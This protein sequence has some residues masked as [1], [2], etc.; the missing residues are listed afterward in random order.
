MSIKL[1]DNED[2]F[3]CH[4]FAAD[5]DLACKDYVRERLG[6]PDW[7][8][9]GGNGNGRR[10]RTDAEITAAV[11]QAA[12]A[13][14]TTPRKVVARYQ[15]CD[16]AGAILYE[17]EK[18]DPKGFRQRRKTASGWDYQLGDVRR[19]LY[20][21]PDLFAWP[22]ANVFV[23]E[24]E[25]DCENVAALG[26]CTTWAASGR[27]E[28]VDVSTL[29]GRD[30]FII[31]DNDA[32]K[33]GEGK[34]LAAARALHDVVRTIKIVQLPRPP[35]RQGR[36]RLAAKPHQGGVRRGLRLGAGVGAGCKEKRDRGPAHIVR[37]QGCQ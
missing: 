7:K 16:E 29:H 18:F 28:G 6:R 13:P 4:L 22:D 12:M 32:N 26:L 30:V 20:R 19:V 31:A 27:W 21:L 3:V 10:R 34:A 35:R 8:P 2:G 33:A 36:V 37:R 5:D 9:N 1:A 24:G 23:C 17:V 14:E 11:M 15:Y 25:K